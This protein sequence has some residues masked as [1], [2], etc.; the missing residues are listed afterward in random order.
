MTTLQG[1]INRVIFS[2]PVND[3]CVLL[4]D[5]ISPVKKAFIVKGYMPEP[6]ESVDVEA[7]GEFILD[8]K[9]GKEFEA[10]HLCACIPTSKSGLLSYLSS[11]V[12]KGIG[13]S[14]ARQIVS[15]FGDMSYHVLEH[16]PERLL[17]VPGIG[18]KKLETIR[19]SWKKNT[20]M[21][22]LSLMLSKYD[23]SPA[24]I[25][26][27]Y[28]KYK[29]NAVNVIT[30]NPYRLADEVN[31]IGFKKADDI[32]RK[33]GIEKDSIHRLKAGLKYALQQASLDGHVYITR[34]SLIKYASGLLDVAGEE[35]SKAL[36]ESIIIK[37]VI[38]EDGREYL[39]YLYK[40][41]TGIARCVM[42]LLKEDNTAKKSYVNISDIE[43]TLHVEYDETQKRAITLAMKKNIMI[44]T[45]GPGTGKSTT[46]N[47]IVEAIKRSGVDEDDILLAAPTG[48]AAK[49][50][51]E[52]VGMPAATIHRILEYSPVSGAFNRNASAPLEGFAL[53]V[54]EASMIDTS[55][56]FHLLSAVPDWMKVILVGDVDQLPSVG[57]GNVLNDLIASG[58][59]PTIKL[60]KIFRQ[61]AD[62]GIVN[63][64][65]K[66]NNGI[67]PVFN[68][69]EDGQDLFKLERTS[70]KAGPTILYLVTQYIPERFG[71]S[72][73]DVMVLTPMK[74]GPVG[75][76]ALNHMLQEV[77]NPQGKG[78]DYYDIKFRIGDKVMQVRNDYDKE[79][80]NGDLG[81]IENIIVDSDDEENMLAVR[82][83]SGRLVNYEFDELDELTLAYACT[84]HKS[85]GSEYPI[86][87]MAMMN[88]HYVMLQKNLLY[89]GLTR[90]KK[91]CFLVCNQKALEISVRN[92]EMKKRNTTLKERIREL[93]FIPAY[94]EEE[95]CS[96]G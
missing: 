21:R 14:L 34:D 52:V 80:F 5:C 10:S 86:V 19:E 2:S 27:I 45:G 35:V 38:Q 28:R 67:V 55:L 13:P 51:E 89:T 44:L 53:I 56:M 85:Q 81:I 22:N 20:E 43:E 88:E 3:F 71:V 42:S 4:V 6:K 39:P 25:A 74:K 29:E 82:F 75:T 78:I 26:K 87:V 84:I 7:S 94:T 15:K 66:V 73:K 31:G 37:D 63:T 36:E 65:H 79:V 96:A 83:E 58:A 72:P 48:R 11:K 69:Y 91:E 40:Q 47:G 16:E 41:E 32:A 92:A 95:L 62:S 30:N 90:A 49:R 77:I 24:L 17:E 93:A 64:A 61:A 57:P 23:I 50:M 59:I 33:M 9:Y 70:E 60:T 18:K 46:V 76:A 8:K 68:N 54:D 1:T 12:I